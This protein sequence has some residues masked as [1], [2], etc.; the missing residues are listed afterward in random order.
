MT[1]GLTQNCLQTNFEN[2][3]GGL[4]YGSRGRGREISYSTGEAL[5]A[6]DGLIKES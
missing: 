5:G 6:G 4:I 3:N 2:Q 1:K